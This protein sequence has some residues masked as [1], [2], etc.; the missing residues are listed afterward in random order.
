MMNL[1]SDGGQ[2]FVKAK[3]A[4]GSWAKG[5]IIFPKSYL[6]AAKTSTCDLLLS[7]QKK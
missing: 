3:D 1:Q 6:T 4:Y 2:A 7:D 5:A